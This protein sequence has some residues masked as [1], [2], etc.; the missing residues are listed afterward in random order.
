MNRAVVLKE[1]EVLYK[2]GLSDAE[3][4]RRQKR[5]RSSIRNWRRR[6]GL[7][8]KTTCAECGGPVIWVDDAIVCLICGAEE[9]ISDD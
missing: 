1:R 6:R 9:P 3:I 4:G 2:Q 8:A 5:N 7:Q